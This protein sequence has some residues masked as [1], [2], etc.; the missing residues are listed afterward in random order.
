MKELAYGV[1]E[2]GWWSWVDDSQDPHNSGEACPV[3]R[4]EKQVF[5]V[6]ALLSTVIVY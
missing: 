2:L 3:E 6:R 4:K 1:H 5:E